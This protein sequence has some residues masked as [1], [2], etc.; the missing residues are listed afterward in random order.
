[1]ISGESAGKNIDDLLIEADKI[2]SET[3]PYF[4]TSSNMNK[5]KTSKDYKSI[6]N[7]TKITSTQS[8][9]QKNDT[10]KVI[11]NLNNNSQRSSI[12]EKQS[13]TSEIYG[14]Y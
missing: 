9:I 3:L 8:K 10:K 14:L 4:Q 11:F 7:N 13:N 1:M 2:I 6:Q 5:V 12:P